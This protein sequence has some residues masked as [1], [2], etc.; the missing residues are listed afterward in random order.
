MVLVV[1]E[2]EKIRR[3]SNDWPDVIELG[4]GLDNEQVALVENRL[5]IDLPSF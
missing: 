1:N 2:I 5:A 4:D 3:M